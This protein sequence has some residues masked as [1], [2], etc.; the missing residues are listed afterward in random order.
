[1]NKGHKYGFGKRRRRV[2][3]YV[4]LEQRVSSGTNGGT[5]TATVWNDRV[6]NT[7]VSDLDNLCALDPVT[8][9]FSVDSG[10]YRLHVRALHWAV[11]GMVR[12]YDPTGERVLAS[13]VS[14]SS[15]TS[16]SFQM[17]PGTLDIPIVSLP[18]APLKLQTYTQTT[19]SNNGL[20]IPASFGDE[21]VYAQLLLWRLM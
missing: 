13:G 5:C 9:V 1:M 2:G 21:E 14:A 15:L 11:R 12:L 19:Q 7:K 4:H 10:E 6:L 16:T 8:G 3:A 20:G 18:S 17:M